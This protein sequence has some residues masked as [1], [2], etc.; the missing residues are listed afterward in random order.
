MVGVGSAWTQD[1]H[2]SIRSADPDMLPAWVAGASL[3]LAWGGEVVCGGDLPEGL[4]LALLLFLRRLRGLLALLVWAARAADRLAFFLAPCLCGRS[5]A[6]GHREF[7]AVSPLMLTVIFAVKC[8]GGL[9][10]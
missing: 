7:T 2:S 1:S 9:C 5:G 4:S 8:V 3:E 10:T 6:G